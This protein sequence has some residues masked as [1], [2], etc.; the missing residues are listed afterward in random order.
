MADDEGFR[1]EEN[2]SSTTICVVIG[3]RS[4]IGRSLVSLLLK[5]DKWI[6]RIADSH[7]SINLDLD[8]KNSLL[9]DAISS[10][11]ASYFQVDVRHKSQIIKAIEGSTVVFHMGT[12][13]P[14]LKDVHL[15]YLITVQG[16]KNVIHACRECKVERLV[17]NSSAD[18]VFDGKHD[19]VNGDDSMSYP[20]RF[21]DMLSDL[22]AQ[23][24]ALVLFA[25]NIDGLLTC[26]LR[27][28][29]AF[30]PGEAKLVPFLLNAAKTGLAKFI[31]GNGENICDF[32]YV[33]NIAHA[34]I[35]TEEAL[36][37]RA[38][39]VAGKAF[40]VTNLEPVKFWDFVSLILQGFGYP[41]PSVKVPARLIWFLTSL[42]KWVSEQ[43]E[44]RNT[45]SILTPQIVYQF[46]CTTTFSCFGARNQI[47]Y[48][49]IV[50]LEE[51][52]ALTI[53]SFSRNVAEDS[54]MRD[55]AFYK[56]SKSEKLLGNGRVA[57]LLLW[58]DEKK[59][60]TCFLS[61]V[62]LYYWFFL[63]GRTFISSVALFL[64]MISVVL[65]SHGFLPPSLFGFKIKKISSSS[66]F[67][68]S[69]TV[70][71]AI[72]SIAFSWNHCMRTLHLISQGC[73]WNVFVKVF[74]CVYMFQWLVSFSFSTVVGAGIV[75]AFT[76]FF[77][78]MQYE[79]EVDG[80][81]ELSYVGVKNL[82]GSLIKNLPASVASLLHNYNIIGQDEEARG[83]V[84]ISGYGYEH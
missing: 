74:V 79:A 64:L 65:F 12:T 76:T 82:K 54:T 70:E 4:F 71:N 34:H 22:K 8:E 73:D 3:G 83:E 59:T 72:L 31:V 51:G 30:G 61:L 48:S 49:P 57:D 18:V 47:G 78:Y 39:V 21:E 52:V 38:A 55:R 37:S 60:F 5:S 26:A 81:V 40:F 46:T 28:S 42:S 20:F 45:H 62:M 27:S 67:Q 75:F 36:R 84:T 29:N 17:Y 16:T 44:K 33:D 50:S 13:G 69:E 24:E 14:S 15:Q 32:T 19:I 25:N 68:V 6:V 56:P 43:L 58:R 53:E 35:C 10:G 7:P 63:C 41:R 11:R 80:A 2:P 66:E 1:Q 23:A 77:V 9:S